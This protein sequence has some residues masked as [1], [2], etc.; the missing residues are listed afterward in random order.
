[1]GVITN[2]AADSTVYLMQEFV[3]MIKHIRLDR[4]H[5]NLSCISNHYSKSSKT[6]DKA[7]QIFI[8]YCPSRLVLGRLNILKNRTGSRFFFYIS[9]A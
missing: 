2:L 1:M 8:P 9:P 6:E 7:A 4:S 3:L 5:L